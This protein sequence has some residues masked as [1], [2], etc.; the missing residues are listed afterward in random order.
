[1]ERRSQFVFLFLILAQGAHS[2]EEYVTRLYEVFAPARFVSSLVS[3]DLSV[4]FLVVNVALVAFGLWCWAI[5]VRSGWR[6]ARGLAWFWTLLEL[7]NGT[8]H[9]VLAL[10]RGGYFP[11]VA[12]A[13][14]LLLLAAWLAVLQTRQGGGE[15]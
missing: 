4:G 15:S 12:T 1:M 11:G 7:G 6:A 9:L 14:L 13:P 3:K 8:G 2:I 5:P 10:S